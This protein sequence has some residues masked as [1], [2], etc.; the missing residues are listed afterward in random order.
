MP[1]PSR[2]I[3]IANIPY[4]VSEE[5]LANVFSEAGPVQSVDIKFDNATGRSKGYGFVQFADENAALSAVRNLKDVQVN[6]RN[7]RVELSTDT[8][9]RTRGRQRETTHDHPEEEVDGTQRA[10]D[11]ISK[12]LAA[13][14]PGQLQDVMAGM[15]VGPNSRL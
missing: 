15:K 9:V 5:Q 14:S 7:L 6:G 1:P 12:T 3:F 4:D 10:T 13:I 11:V 8:P 2:T